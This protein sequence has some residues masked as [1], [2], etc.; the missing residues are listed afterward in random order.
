LR[1]SVNAAWNLR[2]ARQPGERAEHVGLPQRLPSRVPVEA[3]GRDVPPALLD[4]AGARRLL[5]LSAIT[6]EQRHAVD[7]SRIALPLTAQTTDNP[8][9]TH[10]LAGIGLICVWRVPGIR[11]TCWSLRESVR[12]SSG[13]RRCWS[14]TASPGVTR[15]GL[16]R[17]SAVRC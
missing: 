15:R 6:G 13:F 11:R 17:A 1:S 14:Q 10:G 2:D 3:I 16:T 7:A 9:L 12:G 8:D 4:H 5:E